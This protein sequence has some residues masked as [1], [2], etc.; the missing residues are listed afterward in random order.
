[1]KR[2]GIVLLLSM[3]A[4]CLPCLEV[5]TGNLTVSAAPR[6][7]LL[8]VA[9]ATHLQPL[10]DDFQ[11]KMGLYADFPLHIQ[12][13]RNEAVYHAL[14]ANQGVLE[15]SEAF[16]DGAT[17][18]V[19]IRHPGDLRHVERLGAIL[20]HE[21]IHA[22][23]NHYWRDAPLWFHE[24]MAVY[25]TEGVGF[26]RAVQYAQ[27]TLLGRKLLLEQMNAYPRSAAD[28]DFFY[29]KSAL[30]MQYLYTQRRAEFY[31]LWDLAPRKGGRFDVALAASMGLTRQDLGAQVDR[32]LKT[33]ARWE[34]LLASSSVIW[35][36][37]PLLLLVGWL[38]SQWRNRRTKKGWERE[39]GEED[40]EK[41]L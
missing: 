11:T 16:Y 35:G 32:Y 39:E 40:E 2:A 4:I 31:R 30:T 29:A 15:F 17:Q 1:V 12:I 6:D 10:I 8:A 22:Y 3:L 41:N 33:R 38:R 7:S 9:V 14:T 18:T 25:F 36:G 13:A 21:Y 19:T 23:V 24:G 26:E 5:R 34:I 28:W 20:L 37:M 27:A